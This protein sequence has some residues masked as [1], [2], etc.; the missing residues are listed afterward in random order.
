MSELYNKEAREA[1]VAHAEELVASLVRV[2]HDLSRYKLAYENSIA[3][4]QQQLQIRS[5]PLI[6]VRDEVMQELAEIFE[7]LLPTLDGKS[8]VL[9][10]G[11]VAER[12]TTS[13]EVDEALLMERARQLGIVRLV[14]E[15]QPRKVKKLLINRLLKQRPDFVRKLAKALTQKKTRH[16]TVK[17]PHEQ[18]E[19]ERDLHPLR[20]TLSVES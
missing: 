15:P 2:E 4:Y 5:E 9:R 1:D 17:L 12:A 14:S 13:L 8:L 19:L 3:P 6:G 11:V 16:M 18:V 20:T 7:R 10:S